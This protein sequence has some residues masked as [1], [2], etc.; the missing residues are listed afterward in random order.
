MVKTVQMTERGT[1]E[2]HDQP[3]PELEKGSVVVKT[4]YSGVCGT[5]IH[6]LKG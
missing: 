5:D 4:A 6:L 3:Y 2:L 1:A